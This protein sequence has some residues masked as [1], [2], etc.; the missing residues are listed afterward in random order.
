MNSLRLMFTVSLCLAFLGVLLLTSIA[1]AATGDY[2][3]VLRSSAPG[4]GEEFGY[5]LANCPGW[6]AVGVPTS[7]LPNGPQGAVFVYDAN[8]QLQRRLA[9]PDPLSYEYDE[10]G[11]ALSAVGGKLL[12][13][14]FRADI[15]TSEGGAAYLYDL[16]SGQLLH[17]LCSPDPTGNDWFG[18]SVA[19]VGNRLV[20]GAVNNSAA[21]QRA[22]AAYVFDMGT[23]GLQRTLLP[24][25][26]S[27]SDTRFGSA[28]T[29]V[30]QNKALVGAYHTVIGGDAYLFDLDTGQVLH[31]FLN[32]NP[33]RTH[34]D[35]F[36]LSVAS[37][38]NSLFI[39]A[40][41][42]NNQGAVYEYNATTYA[43]MRTYVSPAGTDGFG[44]SISAWGDYL[45]VGQP[46]DDT[47]AGS[48]QP[49]DIFDG[50]SAFRFD[51]RDGHMVCQL[52]KPLPAHDDQFGG[53]VTLGDG[54][55]AAGAVHDDLPPAFD[56]GG[57]YLF[58][59][60]PEPVTLSLLALG[61]L[62][63]IRRRRK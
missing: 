51:V 35:S 19:I 62:A 36:G 32:P 15:G 8:R 52:Q 25:I 60:V 28:V 11:D 55:M 39:A 50:G 33:T 12:V 23:G 27:G 7:G 45:L 21:G 40:R 47:G 37:A 29:S 59:G 38:G 1:G 22:G 24:D 44:W 34:I 63:L 9:S 42:A 6:L 17:S 43:L 58:E 53:A 57:V 20:A 30:G 54:W 41:Q 2:V 10:F 61:G 56:A 31:R 4:Y 26:A 49:H 14:A 48:Y 18:C 46:F 13:G 16:S 3:Q 5:S